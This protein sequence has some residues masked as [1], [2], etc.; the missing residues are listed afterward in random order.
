[1]SDS[2]D[3]HWIENHL[4]A[5]YCDKLDQEQTRLARAHIESCEFCSREALALNAIDPL[6][7]RHFRREMRMA[8]QPRTVHAGR[9]FG[10]SAATLG[11]VAALLFVALGTPQT[12][13]VLPVPA[14][15]RQ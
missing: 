7:Q 1:M 3:C 13:S 10:L 12:S 9:V 2:I 14:A 6:V 5:Y 15:V 4:E 8:Q 11:L